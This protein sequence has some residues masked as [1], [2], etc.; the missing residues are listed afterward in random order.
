M[1]PS[2]PA[3]RTATLS[4]ALSVALSI[5]AA[6][7]QAVHLVGPGG[8]AEI[9]HAIAVAAPGDVVEIAA[10]TYLPFTLD[11]PLLIRARPGARVGVLSASLATTRL[12]PPPGTVAT[13]SG[14]EF[15]CPWALAGMATRIESGTVFCEECVFEAPAVLG[16]GALA[17]E[18]ATAVLRRC[19]LAGNGVGAGRAGTY[20]PG[21][22]CNQAQVFATD[23][24]LRGSDT[25]FDSYGAGGEGARLSA[26]VA[27]FVRCTIAGGQ[28]GSCLANPPGAGLRTIGETTLWLADC[29]VIGGSA[30]CSIIGTGAAGLQHGG[31]RPAEVA[32]CSL[33][34]GAGATASGPATVGPTVA[35]PLPGL[36]ADTVPLVRGSAFA[37]H[38]RTEPNWPVAVF[39]AI[40]LDV[41]TVPVLAE[42]L[43]LAGAPAPFALL[44]ADAAGDA[45]LRT[46]VPALPGHP[47]A[48]FF[49]AGVSGLALPLHVTP[50]LGG[51]VR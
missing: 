34:G 14:L 18:N 6:Q 16:A 20:N 5:G 50:P 30:N 11:K 3:L 15:R 48:R 12:R 45:V 46:L 25:A 9:S 2:A 49:F 7:A 27:Q 51:V 42:P 31:T 36:G 40:E 13:V 37:I 41:R 35:A 26:S 43:P 10:G 4:V 8:L 39:V 29:S 28:Q 21:L 38:F 23:C 32:R 19:A 17:V 44:F 1:L 47:H 24:W 22:V 33:Q